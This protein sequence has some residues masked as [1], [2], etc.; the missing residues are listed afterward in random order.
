V[1]PAEPCVKVIV[2]DDDQSIHD[3]TCFALSDFRFE[4]RKVEFLSA[5]SG[6]DAVRILEENPDT[7]AIL[8]DVV[9]DTDT[10]GLDAV[11]TIREVIKN[12]FVRIIIRT[13]QPG[14]I[15]EK[16]VIR[17]YDIN[18]YTAKTELTSTRLYITLYGALR[19]YFDLRNIEAA[20]KEIL[21]TKEQIQ[22]TETRHR[23]WYQNVPVMIHSI[24]DKGRLID[25][26]S[27]W[28][29]TLKYKRDEVIGRPSVDFL[30]EA[31][32]EYAVT[33]VLPEFWEKGHVIDVPY[34]MVARD[35]GIID[36]L[37]SANLEKNAGK[38]GPF[39]IAVIKN[40][41][42]QRRAEHALK[43]SEQRL[44]LAVKGGNLG[45]W[46]WD[47]PSGRVTYNRRWADIIGY[48]ID[49]IEQTY[50][51]WGSRLHPDDRENTE[52]SVRGHLN[53]KLPFFE[54]EHRLKTKAG[55][56]RWVLGV[57][58][59]SQTDDQG[60]PT[61]MTG[62]MA[63][64]HHRKQA[65]EETQTTLGEL[66]AL[67]RLGR[68]INAELSLDGV[69][70]RA[71]VTVADAIQ[72]ALARIY[73]VH[74]GELQPR[75]AYSF[76][77][78]VLDSDAPG[79][80]SIGL[81]LCINAFKQQ[82]SFFATDISNRDISN[83]AISGPDILKTT[84]Q[85]EETPGR[86]KGFAAVP[87]IVG[88]E[89][90]GILALCCLTPRRFDRRLDFLDSMAEIL[91]AGINN[92]LLY[93]KNQ[94]YAQ[95]LEKRVEKRTREL[96]R[97]N[98]RLQNEIEDRKHM[99]IEL[100]KRE[101]MLNKTGAM[102]RVGGW[103][104]DTRTDELVW[105]RTVYDIHETGPD[106][107]PELGS[108]L[109]FY[110]P[111]YRADISRLVT[112]CRETGTPYDNEFEII[113][114][115]GNRIWVRAKG[116]PVLKDGKLVK[117]IGS[118]QDISDR[119][120]TEAQLMA[121]KEEA[122]HAN[123]A[124]TDFLARMSHEIRTPMNAILNLTDFVL[125]GR[126]D[127]EQTEYLGVVRDSGRHL[128]NIIND[129]LDLSKIESGRM[130][131]AH[132]PFDLTTVLDT[133]IASLS[134]QAQDKGLY[135]ETR[136]EENLPV[137]FRGDAGRLQ[138]ILL[139][140]TGNAIKFTQAGG[141]EISV[142]SGDIACTGLNGNTRPRNRIQFKIEDTGIGI[143][144]AHK[145]VIFDAFGQADISTSRKY[146]GTGL[147]LT[148]SRQ[149]IELMDGDIW[150]V[151]TPGKGTVF[152]F[153]L[154]LEKASETEMQSGKEDTSR[155]RNRS[156]P[157]R[158]LLAED[159]AANI[160]VAKA[161]IGLL[162]HKLSIA[163]NGREAIDLMKDQLFDL[164]LMDVEMPVMDGITTTRA[165]RRGD[166]GE[167][168]REIRII[169]L[170]AHALTGYREK[171]LAAGMDHYI[172]KPFEPDELARI[173]GR[174]SPS[175]LTE[176]T[177][178]GE[179]DDTGPPSVPGV[180]NHEEAIRRFYGD[181]ELY[182]SLCKDFILRYQDQVDALHAHLQSGETDKAAILAHTLKGNCA[183][184][185]AKT[186]ERHAAAL[187]AAVRQDDFLRANTCL[188]D[189]L[190]AVKS[191]RDAIYDRMQTGYIPIST[192]GT[193]PDAVQGTNLSFEENLAELAAVLKKG[194]GDDQLLAVITALWPPELDETLKDELLARI[195]NFDFAPAGKTLGRIQD[196][197][198]HSRE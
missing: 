11:R 176:S 134:Q 153:S 64:I 30:T 178:T 69:L 155:F 111:E 46:D 57:G 39:S 133:T 88:R 128:L 173:I 60:A 147:G 137:C 103:E 72:P 42:E 166:A 43:T 112:Q 114:A 101:E 183:N 143:D 2:A 138:Q 21:R 78:A 184:I 84:G 9:M 6:S 119:K 17:S 172:S 152:H 142:S 18:D 120:K 66:T 141:I 197:L 131:L 90:I 37:L 94:E 150:F 122:E 53:G 140:L 70:S 8:M 75:Q 115:R 44:N 10:D 126:L 121:A 130:E 27:Q 117:L 106:Y 139:N 41:T 129:I 55:S 116:E 67:N 167:E 169:A 23:H 187:E 198:A 156:R 123:Q 105:T 124:K 100:E 164:V 163:R 4:G 49:E 194:G 89:T 52:N 182:A 136:I 149:I 76:D 1:T 185:G 127:Q 56:W 25:V 14:D 196:A 98:Q 40:V 83:R 13:G 144:D 151:S 12:A 68:E 191:V 91:A 165:I 20:H 80:A 71:I 113:T 157:A 93:Q 48:D 85:P 92:A 180:L 63:D 62:I 145:N 186:C 3:A 146:G 192:A 24:D 36:V 16:K 108:A 118:F 58:K 26:N 15:P 19:A 82:R 99:A 174:V 35:G 168:N 159:N 61:R 102:A 33:Q 74:Q 107:S 32:K 29:T 190:T 148:I 50:D 81:D 54:A 47:M 79:V 189:L 171:C 179:S 161:M 158:I 110:A 170:T 5:Y 28:L 73:I 97:I 77:Q 45:F 104:L 154:C 51:T 22:V 135:L 109:D 34:Q 86:I 177:L 193:Q 31:S 160:K 162:G 7:A 188:S 87:L 195:D 175:M 181:S 132:T 96:T 65:Q 59:V 125:K 38:Q 95:L